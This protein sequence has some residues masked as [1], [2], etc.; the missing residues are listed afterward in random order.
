MKGSYE[1]DHEAMKEWKRNARKVSAEAKTDDILEDRDARWGQ[2]VR[3]MPGCKAPGP[4]KI[5]GWWHKVFPKTNSLLMHKMWEIMDETEK[6]PQWMVRGKTVKIPN[7]GCVGKAEQF[8]PI[9]QTAH[10]CPGGDDYRAHPQSGS[11]TS[12]TKGYP[13]GNKRMP[14]CL[15]S[16]YGSS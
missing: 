14:R 5:H 2:A 4:D 11:P 8:R 16:R 15:N 9:I 1:A 3:K 10:E 6:M 7:E 13:Q 12:R